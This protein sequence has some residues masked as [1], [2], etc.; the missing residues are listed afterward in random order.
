MVTITLTDQQV[1]DLIKQLAPENKKAALFALAEDAQQRR[2]TR[3][4]LAEEQLRR[5]AAESGS[6]WDAMSED[7]RE[8]FVD[9]LI[10]QVRT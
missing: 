7:E 4:M 8:D 3:M 6:K 9:S 5:L 1:I 10:H 2:E